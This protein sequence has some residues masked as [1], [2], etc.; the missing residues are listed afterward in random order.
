MS[1][2]D[3]QHQLGHCPIS[4][5]GDISELSL[6]VQQWLRPYNAY[7]CVIITDDT[8][9]KLYAELLQSAV[10]SAERSCQ[11]L[12]FPAG[13]LSK[14]RE[15]KAALEDRLFALGCTRKTVVIAC[16]GGVVL[17]MAGFIA[18]TYLRG[19][20][21]FYLPTSLLAMVD[22][23][24]G[25]KT[26][27][28]TP[29]GKNLI[30]TFTQPKAVYIDVSFLSTLPVAELW[31]GWSEMVKHAFIKDATL[32]ND[33]AVLADH[34]RNHQS[35]D[36]T[37]WLQ[38]IKS[39]IEVKAQV[40]QADEC[41]RSGERQVLNFGHTVAHAIEAVSDYSITHGDAVR[42]GLWIESY[43]SYQHHEL[44][45]SDWQRIQQFLSL[46][47]I[48]DIQSW[49]AQQWDACIECMFRDK[50]SYVDDIRCVV[51]K[52]LGVVNTNDHQWTI[53]IDQQA[54]RQ[55]CQAYA[56]ELSS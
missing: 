46:A 17:D 28:N 52:A 44:S 39:S 23:S 29:Q 1:S 30:G 20:P 33:L 42:A 9:G 47:P 4:F 34:L 55:A 25:G 6:R 43:L 14:T 24:I 22:A 50:K 54:M 40:V 11:V 41:E 51:L 45:N 2:F 26:A 53:S 27:V 56:K 48:V 49:S 16:G 3:Y 8:V 19:V 21:C 18:A 38:T 12:S 32:L 13:E 5:S 10:Q 36:S 31:Q 7:A 37:L 35:I 15:T